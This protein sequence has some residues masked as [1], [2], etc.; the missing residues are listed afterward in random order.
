MLKN[1]ILY[2]N[3]R[4]L[5]RLFQQAIDDFERRNHVSVT[6]H[7][8]HGIFYSPDGTPLLP[9]RQSHQHH[10]C[11]NGR[12]NSPKYERACIS[13]CAVDAETF[14]HQHLESFIHNCWKGVQEII[15]PVKNR[16]QIQLLLYVGPFRGPQT[17]PEKFIEAWKEL[18]EGNETDYTRISNEMLLLGQGIFAMVEDQRIGG[19]VPRTRRELIREFIHRH[20]HE[21]V[22]LTELGKVLNLSPSRASHLCKHVFGLSFQ[23]LLLKERMSRARNLLLNSDQPLKYIATQVGFSN[24]FYFYRMFRKFYGMPPGEYR[25][26]LQQENRN[27]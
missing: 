11:Q 26:C 16:E 4:N 13:D 18:P 6:I 27:C 23:Y 1:T 22:T 12:K 14:A 24:V 10:F 19:K 5:S 15:V 20:A 9:K 3:V 7:D 17:P 25:I 8:L 2:N 21:A